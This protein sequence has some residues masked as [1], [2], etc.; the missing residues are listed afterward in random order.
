MD[1]TSLVRNTTSGTITG[2][3]YIFGIDLETDFTAP[4]LSSGTD[5]DTPTGSTN[6]GIK[7]TKPGKDVSSTDLRDFVIHS[8]TRSPLVHL[9]KN[10]DYTVWDSTGYISVFHGLGYAPFM[11][12][13][14][15]YGSIWQQVPNQSV[16]TDS[17]Y[18]YIPTPG[19]SSDI[20]TLVLLKEPTDYS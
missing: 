16:S 6:F 15:K 14:R 19:I 12:F 11:F 8:G 17:Q 18:A 5:T 13:Y 9:V 2:R 4:I 7:V 20:Y 10:G 1:S 3:Y